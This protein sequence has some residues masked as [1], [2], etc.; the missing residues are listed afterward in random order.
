M[1]CDPASTS[2]HAR[3]C[4]GTDKG[5]TKGLGK[6]EDLSSSL[7]FCFYSLSLLFFNR[8]LKPD[9]TPLVSSRY[10]VFQNDE[11]DV[12]SRDAV[13]VSRIQKGKR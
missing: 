12:F 4:F 6:G 9:P 8:Q 10:N 1:P 3:D 13:D 11:F 7:H 2:W 5:E